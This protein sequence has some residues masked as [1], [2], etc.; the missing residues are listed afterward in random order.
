MGH[1]AP[2]YSGSHMSP[3]FLEVTGHCARITSLEKSD[4]FGDQSERIQRTDYVS[5]VNEI[6]LLLV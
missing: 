3:I 6:S 1:L 5:S 2:I 4:Q